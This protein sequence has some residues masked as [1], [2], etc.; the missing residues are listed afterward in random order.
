M[1]FAKSILAVLMLVGAQANAGFLFEP[2]AGYTMGDLKIR[3]SANYPLVDLQNKTFSGS[4]DGFAFGAKLAYTFG[5][6]FFLG[7]E[8][9]AARAK[10][11]LSNDSEATD[12]KNTSIFGILGY[13]MRN[14]LR[15]SYGMTVTPH[16]SEEA[17]DPD[18]TI[19]EGNAQKL[20]LGFRYNT[21]FAINV[22]YVIYE[23]DKFK[24]G[25]TV[26]KV[27]D[28]FDKF[29]YTAFLLSIS[30]PFEVGER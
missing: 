6:G 25:S 24:S 28:R 13:Q 29:N 23:L 5:G 18:P 26:G 4:I 17:G 14:G 3:T 1:S 2:Y 8:Y 9:Q 12:W 11:K 27:K 21:P 16:I 10:E 20:S 7:G 19:Y 22:D 15:L 30:F